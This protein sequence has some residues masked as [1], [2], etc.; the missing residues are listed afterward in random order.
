MMKARNYI[1]KCK[2]Y[3]SD[4]K[5]V[6]IKR[7]LHAAEDRMCGAHSEDQIHYSVVTDLTREA[8]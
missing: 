1:S 5:K 3:F 4:K 6:S 7:R 2:Y 8:W